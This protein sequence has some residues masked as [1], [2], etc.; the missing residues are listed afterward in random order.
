MTVVEWAESR[1]PGG[2]VRRD[3]LPSVPGSGESV[4]NIPLESLV[5][6]MVSLKPV[7]CE[8]KAEDRTTDEH[9]I[10]CPEEQTTEE[11]ALSSDEVTMELT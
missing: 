5:V 7:I 8:K 6:L 10:S 9:L 2:R 3:S 4:T 11:T 1:D